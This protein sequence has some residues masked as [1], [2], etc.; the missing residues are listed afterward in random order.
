M[1]RVPLSPPFPVQVK[2]TKAYTQQIPWSQQVEHM[3]VPKGR[4]QVSGT[5]MIYAV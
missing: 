5:V 4:D 1:L 3:Q 2:S